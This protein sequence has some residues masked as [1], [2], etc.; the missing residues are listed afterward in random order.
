M[1]LEVFV[2]EAEKRA[3]RSDPSDEATGHSSRSG[4]TKEDFRQ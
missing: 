1:T 3:M 2:G 4:S